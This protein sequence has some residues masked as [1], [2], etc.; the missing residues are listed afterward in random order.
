[1]TRVV[2]PRDFG[3]P[4]QLELVE[5]DTPEPGEGE[6][7][8]AV[9][10]IGVNPVDWYHYDGVHSD[11]PEDLYTYGYEVAGVVEAVGPGVTGFAEG[12]DV[13]ASDIPGNG[14]ADHVVVPA[15]GLLAKP[16]GVSWEVAASVPVAAGTA[17]HALEKTHVGEG[18]VV[19]AHG[20]AG[21]VGALV[22]QLAVQ[23][24]ARVIAT[25]SSANHDYVRSLGAEPVAY[26]P[27]LTDRVRALAPD[28]V[29]V[30]LDLVGTDEALETSIALVPDRDRVLT[31]AAFGRAAEL[32]IHLIGNGPGADPGLEVR[33]R[34]RAEVLRLLAEGRI[35]IP[36]ERTWPLSE[37]ADAHRASMSRHRSGK[38][39]VVP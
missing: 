17:Y 18:D 38:L 37:V 9:R 5:V 11:D 21:G 13:V 19:V 8:V 3:G 31:I 32:G 23:R 29:D 7:R 15:S 39:V 30:A 10:A 33:P 1:V 26:G 12:D 20:A 34:G 4:D 2:Q 35:D 14:Y 25:A 24:G 36:I 27:G 28:G 6:V 22:V 16:A